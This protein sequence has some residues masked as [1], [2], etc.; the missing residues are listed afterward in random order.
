MQQLS[1]QTG[2]GT[3]FTMKTYATN[4][5]SCYGLL[6][7]N[8]MDNFFTNNMACCR[9]EMLIPL[10]ATAVILLQVMLEMATALSDVT[11]HSVWFIFKKTSTL[12][13]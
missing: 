4:F 8:S 7:D 9:E 6:Y 1:I 5:V 12:T 3:M 2:L 13:N 10:P 11:L